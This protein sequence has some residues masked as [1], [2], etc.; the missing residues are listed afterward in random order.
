MEGIAARRGPVFA[1][2]IVASLPPQYALI[3]VTI[4]KRLVNSLMALRRSQGDPGYDVG[5]GQ[6]SGEV[7]FSEARRLFIRIRVHTEVP[8]NIYPWLRRHYLEIASAGL[9]AT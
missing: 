7:V 3:V 6:D 4:P 1:S 2:G 8:E 9:S 5:G